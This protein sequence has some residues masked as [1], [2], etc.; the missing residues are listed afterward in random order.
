MLEGASK[1]FVWSRVA[2]SHPGHRL[3]MQEVSPQ[4]VTKQGGD[5]KIS[6][7][8]L[9][10]NLVITPPS[11]WIPVVCS[12][13]GTT[14]L[15]IQVINLEHHLMYFVWRR[16]KREVPSL[17]LLSRVAHNKTHVSLKNSPHDCCHGAVA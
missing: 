12:G 11:L 16:S 3:K 6:I 13:K 8:Q 2:S 1:H 5:L 4:A 15:K 10:R 7:S 9:K 17:T 14:K